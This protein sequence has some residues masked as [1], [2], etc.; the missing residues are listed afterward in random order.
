MEDIP[1]ETSADDLND[2]FENAPCGYL[3][4]EPGGKI[5]KAN[6]TF[7]G[8]IGHS[9]DAVI[10][11]RLHD[12]LNVAGRIYYETH[13]APLLRMQGHFNEVALDFVTGTGERLPVL[14]NALERKS[15]SGEVLF[16]RVTVFN[17]TDRRRYEQELLAAKAAADTANALLRDLNATLEA[18]VT[19]AVA[20]RL[21][22]EEAR[23]QMQKMEALGQLTGGVAHDFNNMLAAVMGALSL[24][25][26]RLQRGEGVSE[27][28]A[29]AMDSAKR[30][31]QLTQRLLAFS[32][33][34]PLEL[35]VVNANRVV[36]DMSEILKRTLGESTPV[37]AVLAGGL[38]PV[39]TDASQLENAILN[40][41]INARDA[42]PEGGK[43]TIETAN[44]HLDDDYA[45]MHA[46]VSAGQYV[47]IAVTDTG[48]GM[49]EEVMSRVF[50][51]FFTTK[52]VGKGTGLG[53]SQVFGYI[54]QDRG[55]VK[56]YSE[57]G[58][59]TTV[60]LYLPR[61]YGEHETQ[62]PRH[63][64]AV[65]LSGSASEVILLVEDDERVR[66][67]ASASLRELGYTVIAP[68]TPAA[69]L[70]VIQSDAKFSVLFTDVVMPEINGR[71][72]AELARTA[73]PDLR[74][75]FTTGYTRNA[76]VHNGVL[77]PGVNFLMKPYTLE[78]LALKMRDVL[79]GPER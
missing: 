72:L 20:E 19:E 63:R 3:S 68:P 40:L 25:D 29:G 50:D 35:S 28:I 52:P 34:L 42:M 76:I 54:K 27:L 51:P 48:A 45:R 46:E 77:D 39:R 5:V 56:I 58:Y 74:V 61:H 41:A 13:F 26:R 18:R 9:P 75:V 67:I 30:A 44:A 7:C 15:T 4:L 59:G 12:F 8:W 47:M 33:R 57:V 16:T 24:I 55:H 69:A 36:G 11:K 62:L 49:T 60:K 70:Q 31:A 14:V 32:R 43:I 6:A 37:E 22:A 73:R 78:Q 64:A 1:A 23:R 38:W 10:G 53:L 66:Q 79:A 65:A 21:E 2:L 71:R 17:S